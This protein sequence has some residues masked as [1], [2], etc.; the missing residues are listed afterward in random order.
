MSSGTTV[1][2][3]PMTAIAS[4]VRIARW[5]PSSSAAELPAG[6]LDAAVPASITAVAMASPIAPPTW[7]EV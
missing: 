7:N 1:I 2:A 5:N 3:M 6:E 4:E